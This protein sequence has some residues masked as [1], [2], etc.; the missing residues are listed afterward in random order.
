[1]SDNYVSWQ[2]MACKVLFIVSNGF[3]GIG[4]LCLIISLFLSARS[5]GPSVIAE[6]CMY[7]LAGK[8]TLKSLNTEILFSIWF[9]FKSFF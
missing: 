9:R 2:L 1:M 5:R 6:G 7:L 4:F 3:L 8:L